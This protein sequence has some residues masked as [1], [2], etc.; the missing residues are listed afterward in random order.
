MNIKAECWNC[1]KE[2]EIKHTH[3]DPLSAIT[4]EIEPCNNIDCYDCKECESD[5]E[6]KRLKKIIDDIEPKLL[7]IK[8]SLNR[9]LPIE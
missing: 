5:Q 8:D 2:L 6:N 7:D 4:I 3:S 9:V 1:K